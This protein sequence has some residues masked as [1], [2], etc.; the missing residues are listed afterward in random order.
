[1]SDVSKMIALVRIGERQVDNIDARNDP[2]RY[3]VVSK[4]RP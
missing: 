2:V 4:S 3:G 1:M